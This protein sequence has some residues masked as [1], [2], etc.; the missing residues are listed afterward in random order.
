MTSSTK[1]EP[2]ND[3]VIISTTSSELLPPALEGTR[4]REIVPCEFGGLYLLMNIRPTRHHLGFFIIKYKTT[5]T[6]TPNPRIAKKVNRGFCLEDLV[7]ESRFKSSI[8]FA[9]G[10]CPAGIPLII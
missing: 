7:E 10:G 4:D 3:D 1:S 2:G 9:S 6:T 8:D 5:D